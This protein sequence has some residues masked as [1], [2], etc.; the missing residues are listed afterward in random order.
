MDKGKIVLGRGFGAKGEN[1]GRGFGC[2]GTLL[3]MFKS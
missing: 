1:K 3:R 2:Y